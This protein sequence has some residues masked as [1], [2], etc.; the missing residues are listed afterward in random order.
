MKILLTQFATYSDCLLTTPIARQIKEYDYPDCNLTWL[1]GEKFKD[2]LLNNPYVDQILF[3]PG[4]DSPEKV[5][6]SRDNINLYI[7]GLA[8]SGHVFDKY[9]ILDANTENDSYYGATRRWA[10]FTTYEAKYNHK[11]KVSPQPLIFLSDSEVA[12][13][14]NFIQ[15]YKLNEENCYP[16]LF[17]CSPQ[18]A[19]SAMNLK[20]AI[21]ISEKLVQKYPNIKI[22][23]S[24]EEKVQNKNGMII[25]GSILSF[26][27]N[28]ELLNHCRLLIGSSSGITWLNASNWSRGIDTVQTISAEQSCSGR[29][30]SP[31]VE[32]DNVIFKLPSDN[33]LELKS[34][35]EERLDVQNIY[36]C[37]CC[38]FEN[39]MQKTKEIYQE[40]PGKFDISEIINETLPGKQVQ[41][42]RGKYSPGD[43]VVFV[44][45]KPAQCGVYN[46][47]KNVY[48][49]I[50]RSQKYNFI[51]AECE[52]LKEMEEVISANR[53]KAV[54]YNY[55][56]N[57]ELSWIIKFNN[58]FW[59]KRSES[60]IFDYP[61]LQLGIIH[62]ITQQ[63]ADSA[64]PRQRYAPIWDSANKLFDYYIAPD[65]TLLLRNSLVFKTARPLFKYKNTNPYPEIPVFSSAS[66][67]TPGK[68][69]EK[70]VELI[71]NEYDEAEIRLNIPYCDYGD[72][73]YGYVI[74]RNCRNLIYKKGIRM[75]ITHEYF[76][77]EELL[78]F[79]AASSANFFLYEESGENRGVSSSIDNAL[80]VKRPI[81]ISSS[82]MFRH[83]S[84]ARPS[85][86][87]DNNSIREIVSNGFK[88][89]EKYYEDWSQEVLIWD[90]ERILDKTLS[91]YQGGEG[92]IAKYSVWDTD[93][94]GDDYKNADKNAIYETVKLPE[95]MGLNRVLDDISR[96]VY[97]SAT[98]KIFD[99]VPR[100]MRKKIMRANVNQGF[101]FDT[102]HRFLPEYDNPK[103]LCVGSNTDTA[104]MALIK[105]GYDVEEIDPVLNYDLQ[106][107][108]TKPTTRKNFYDIIFSTSVI[109]HD[110]DDKTFMEC[111]DGLLSGNGVFI[112][113][114]DF[115]DGWS[116]GEPKPK[117]DERLYT[118]NDLEKR[119][120]S[121]MKNCRLL[122]RPDYTG[123]KPDFLFEGVYYNFASFVVRKI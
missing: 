26:R 63:V 56:P 32:F 19:Q 108:F 16:I 110:P 31:S 118:V 39:G 43:N 58:V 115:K 100:E 75:T 68:G 78:D 106:T 116:K 30:L 73:N 95:N 33:I 105:M 13:V 85:I 2:V 15:E 22:V 66:L 101:V 9:F 42:A 44:N 6:F 91:L 98:D 11:I 93:I 113:T 27:E 99:L 104:C 88:P 7:K 5:N 74:A 45:G 52:N 10:Y 111:I 69:F 60:N 103:I 102:V 50:M 23:L 121:Y 34:F 90:Y 117:V 64:Q 59:R 80:S 96:E 28:A 51:Y 83:V 21:S 54:I 82:G 107:F 3:A 12:K 89:L 65:P 25:D 1:I 41:A 4:A 114:C 62:E 92:N 14:G 94:S 84:D 87:I 120:L 122:D 79:L 57:A 109:E 55:Q 53:P 8:K 86:C 77:P 47:G 24:S 67:A 97:K 72:K 81:I 29:L 35:A 49:I 61:F 70:M 119:L 112:M 40:Y 48:N 18:S 37:V 76:T 20:R 17:E 123:F 36:D 71:Q 38:V 46:F